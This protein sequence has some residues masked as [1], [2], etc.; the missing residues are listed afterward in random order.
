MHCGNVSSL[1]RNTSKQPKPYQGVP[2]NTATRDLM[3]FRVCGSPKSGGCRSKGVNTRLRTSG[4]V[5]RAPVLTE[6]SGRSSAKD[7]R[8]APPKTPGNGTSGEATNNDT[9][10]TGTVYDPGSNYSQTSKRP[11]TAVSLGTRGVSPP[12]HTHNVTRGDTI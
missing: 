3:E 9:F 5:V 7:G 2:F 10:V 1:F 4:I 11:P 8:D 12:P 6:G